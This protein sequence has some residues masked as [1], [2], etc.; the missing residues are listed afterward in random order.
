MFSRT[1][2]GFWR[3]DAPEPFTYTDDY[4][5]RQSTTE[6]MAF[7]RL[8]WI[9]SFLSVNALRGAV[10][11]DVGAGNRAMEQHLGRCINRVASYDVAG[12]SIS[13]DELLSTPWDLAIFADV[14]EHVLDIDYAWSI[15][16]RYAYISFPETPR[17]DNWEEL[18]DWRHFKPHEHIWMLNLLGVGR[19]ACERHGCR[20]LG[21]GHIED[22]IRTRW[23]A[24]RPNI[25]SLLVC[26]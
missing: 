11:V 10:V 13:K 5:A 9:G 20:I 4:A 2:Y 25:S 14:I 23:H 22:L 26:R 8:G 12:D 3:Q 6:A 17:V 24:D 16:W 15:P 18:K 7:L 1:E 19:L 21:E